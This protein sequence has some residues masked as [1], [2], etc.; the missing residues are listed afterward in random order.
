MPP[1]KRSS[2]AAEEYENDDGF[3][4]D[5]PKSKKAR[6]IKSEKGDKAPKIGG[7]TGQVSGGG[8]VSKDGEVYWE[9]SMLCT[10]IWTMPN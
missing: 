3:V 2:A 10:V 6:T 8:T 4:E 5:A 7:S 1:K 9:V